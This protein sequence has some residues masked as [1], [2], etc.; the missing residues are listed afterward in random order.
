M[1]A[2]PRPPTS[3]PLLLLLLLLLLASGG[4]AALAAP[5]EGA[6]APPPPASGAVRPVPGD[7]IRPFEPP[8]HAYGPGHRGVDLTAV[9]GD[10]VRAALPGRIAYAGLVAGTGWVTVDHGGGLETTYGPVEQ[11]RAVGAAVHRGQPIGVVAAG[12][13]H[14]DWGA[15][16]DGAYMDP[17][18]LLG[19]WRLHLV[20]A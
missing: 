4:P 1:P 10:A 19:L 6:G 18:S 13:T 3:P 11:R 5:L 20:G 7:V 17:M 8:A 9:P 12:G 2:P 15:R 16:R 14:L